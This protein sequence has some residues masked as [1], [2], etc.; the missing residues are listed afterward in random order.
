M[1]PKMHKRAG[2]LPWPCAFIEAGYAG[3]P[4][5]LAF[6]FDFDKKLSS[7]KNLIKVL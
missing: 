5:N 2:H 3:S 1:I 4:A 7:N 6:L